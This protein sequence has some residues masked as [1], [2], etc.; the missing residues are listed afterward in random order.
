MFGGSRPIAKSCRG[1]TLLARGS[2]MLQMRDR[3]VAGVNLCG[4]ESSR[5]SPPTSPA[6]KACSQESSEEKEVTCF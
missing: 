4:V 6:S 2:F 3:M 1:T 5:F